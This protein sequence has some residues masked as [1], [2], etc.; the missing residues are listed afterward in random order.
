MCVCVRRCTAAAEGINPSAGQ[1]GRGGHPSGVLKNTLG[2][3]AKPPLILLIPSPLGGEVRVTHLLGGFPCLDACIACLFL[4]SFSARWS[5]ASST[6]EI[7]YTPLMHIV[8]DSLNS[9]ALLSAITFVL[10][11]GR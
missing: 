2:W 7:V 4:I 1:V 3:I 8:R 10:L 9:A 11:H 5:S 6:G